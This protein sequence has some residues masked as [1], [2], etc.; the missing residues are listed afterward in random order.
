MVIRVDGRKVEAKLREFWAE[1][2]P[3]GHRVPPSARETAIWYNGYKAGVDEKR[4]RAQ[5]AKTRKL[6]RRKKR[7]SAARRT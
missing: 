1:W 3:P 4:E 5:I 2:M 6:T 7:K